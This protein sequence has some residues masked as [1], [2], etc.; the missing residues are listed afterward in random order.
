M[1]LLLEVM[2]EGTQEREIVR[3]AVVTGTY[4]STC[5]VL[6]YVANAWHSAMRIQFGKEKKILESVHLSKDTF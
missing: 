6:V 5:H 4:T 1:C 2:L 3:P